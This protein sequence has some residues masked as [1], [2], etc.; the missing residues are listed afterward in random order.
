[1]D[2]FIK[3]IIKNKQTC[4]FISPHLDDAVLSAGGLVK[5]LSSK[6]KI[7][8]INIFTQAIDGKQTVSAWKY[9]KDMGYNKASD[10]FADRQKEDKE[11]L[12]QLHISP[13]NLGFPDALWRKKNNFVA[14]TLGNVL[15][16][17]KH[18]YPTYRFHI[19]NGK[20]SS[21]DQE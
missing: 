7:M 9:I 14:K 4:I 19:T 8:V 10:L 12:F 5:F 2:T 16:E 11:A 1:M 20:V 17:F 3:I 15:P 13:I 18:V 6:T 21:A